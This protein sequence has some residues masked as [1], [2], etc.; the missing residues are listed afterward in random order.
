MHQ[1]GFHY[2]A[3]PRCTAN[4]TFLKRGK[5]LLLCMTSAQF[6]EIISVTEF[7]V[8]LIFV[9]AQSPYYKCCKLFPLF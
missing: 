7:V 6:S 4:K 2:T 9:Y 8:S 1:V 3:V 5:Y